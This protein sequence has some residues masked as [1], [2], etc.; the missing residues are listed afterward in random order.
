MKCTHRQQTASKKDVL[1]VWK[2]L[3]SDEAL[4]AG[5]R[6]PENKGIPE[7]PKQSVSVEEKAVVPGM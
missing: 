2:S 3:E 5:R 1:G 7:N 6:Y 4:G